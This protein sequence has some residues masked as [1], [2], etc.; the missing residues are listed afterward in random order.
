MTLKLTKIRGY[1]E[2][3]V[4]YDNGVK[5]VSWLLDG[6]N[7]SVETLTDIIDTVNPAIPPTKPAIPLASPSLGQLFQAASEVYAQENAGA[8]AADR[9][10]R[11]EEMRLRNGGAALARGIG[12]ENDGLPVVDTDRNDLGSVNW[13]V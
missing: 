6:Q 5:T 2:Y 11:Q 1:D 3:S 9:A 10:A 12:M 8:E 13:G 7:V 4:V